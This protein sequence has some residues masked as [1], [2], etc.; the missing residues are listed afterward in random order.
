MSDA[1]LTRGDAPALLDS[2]PRRRIQ[3]IR[4]DI[5]E[6]LDL[7]LAST[8]KLIAG[9]IPA[10]SSAGI[11]KDLQKFRAGLFLPWEAP[12]QLGGARYGAQADLVGGSLLTPPLSA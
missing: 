12:K 3:E 10:V 2:I 8:V 9:G 11:S 6:T 5:D 1:T 7:F 4:K